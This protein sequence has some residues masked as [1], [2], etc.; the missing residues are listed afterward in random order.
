MSLKVAICGKVSAPS[1]IVNYQAIIMIKFHINRILPCTRSE[2]RWRALPH[3]ERFVSP[4]W[5]VVELELPT[6]FCLKQKKK[7]DTV[8]SS[9]SWEKPLQIDSEAGGPSCMALLVQYCVKC[10]LQCV[11]VDLRQV[12]T[13][14]WIL[15]CILPWIINMSISKWFGFFIETPAG[16]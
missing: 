11:R 3:L 15:K 14:S 5:H 7:Q 4:W 12:T 13:R 2:F 1:L 16:A 6:V 10:G 8:G 9:F